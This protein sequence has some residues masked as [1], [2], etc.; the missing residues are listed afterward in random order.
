MGKPVDLYGMEMVLFS[1]NMRREVNL[2]QI[3]KFGLS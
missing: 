2:K 1:D 3:L